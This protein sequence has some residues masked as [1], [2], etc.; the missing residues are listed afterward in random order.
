M[1][2]KLISNQANRANNSPRANRDHGSRPLL[3]RRQG[4]F[5]FCLQSGQQPAQPCCI[6]EHDPTTA[7]GKRRVQIA[8]DAQAVF[9]RR[10]HQPRRP[11]PANIRPGSP[12][13]VMGPGTAGVGSKEPWDTV[14]VSLPSISFPK[15]G[16]G[17]V[18]DG[19][20]QLRREPVSAEGYLRFGI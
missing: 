11:P 12:A 15:I 19:G 16:L 1:G 3:A 2:S 14:R 7:L 18:N 17:E 10:R 5:W 13:P 20:F 4:R 6:W 8:L 9:C